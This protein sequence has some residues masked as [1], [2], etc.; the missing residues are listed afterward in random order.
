MKNTGPT[1]DVR[2]QVFMRDRQ[3]CARCGGPGI[4]IHHRVGRGAGGSSDPAINLPANLV[5]LC[6]RCHRHLT[7]HPAEAYETGWS[8][9]RN[10]QDDP[11][12]VPLTDSWGFRF[13]LTND[14]QIERLTPD[15]LVELSQRYDR[16]HPF[17]RDAS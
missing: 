14:G 10:S 16:T 4:E 6:S 13:R 8:V 9:R 3:N 15:P 1:K 5:L 7:E 17:D 11:D 12:Q 2:W